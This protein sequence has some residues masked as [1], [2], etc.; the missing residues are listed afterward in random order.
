LIDQKESSAL[1]KDGLDE[2]KHPL[3]LDDGVDCDR[4]AAGAAQGHPAVVLCNHRQLQIQTSH[5]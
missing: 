1:H 5:F 4:N 3:S 2:T